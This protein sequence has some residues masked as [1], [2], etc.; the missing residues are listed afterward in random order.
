MQPMLVGKFPGGTGASGLHSP[1]ISVFEDI[2][3]STGQ[4]CIFSFGPPQGLFV[5]VFNDR[6]NRS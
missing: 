2:D 1:L 5:K 3:L 6:T 4:A